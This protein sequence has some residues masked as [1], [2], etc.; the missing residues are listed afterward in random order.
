MQNQPPSAPRRTLHIPFLIALVA[1]VAWQGFQMVELVQARSS[2]I[3]TRD[4]QT[5]PMTESEKVRNQFNVLVGRTLELSRQGDADA[6]AII[7]AFAKRGVTFIPP[8]NQP[9]R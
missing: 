6:K 7:D 2:L 8:R 3:A 4:G 9:A 1:F 5:G